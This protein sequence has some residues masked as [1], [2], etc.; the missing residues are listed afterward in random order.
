MNYLIV[1][2]M[3]V[4]TKYSFAS[5][6]D[7]FTDCVA[8]RSLNNQIDYV[9]SPYSKFLSIEEWAG[10]QCQAILDMAR[11]HQN[12]AIQII[13]HRKEKLEIHGQCPN[14]L[15]VRIFTNKNGNTVFQ[16][17]R[18]NKFDPSK[19]DILKQKDF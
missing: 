5:S 6:F 9:A 11:E 2:A 19:F 14:C 10:N 17:G 8:E 12:Q 16:F 4:S 13:D 18:I 15:Q 3:L 1:V 7:A